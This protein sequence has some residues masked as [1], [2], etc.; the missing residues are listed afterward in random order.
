MEPTSPDPDQ[1]QEPL[2]ASSSGGVK[3]LP[4]AVAFTGMGLSA[5][6]CVGVGVFLGVWLDG[7]THTAPLFLIVGLVLGVAAAVGSV[8]TQVRRFL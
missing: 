6:I 2:D 4:G 5:A 8:V 3:P 1:P 7:R